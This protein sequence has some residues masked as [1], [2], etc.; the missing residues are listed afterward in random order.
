MKNK[1]K[2]KINLKYIPHKLSRKDK[3]KQYNELMKSK[4]MYKKDK[5]YIRK[6]IKGY[7]TKKSKHKNKFM[8]MYN[9]KSNELNL[10]LISKKTRCNKKG[11]KKIINKGMGAYFSSGSRPNQT[12]H[13]WGM[14]RLYSALTN[15]PSAVIDKNILINNCHK[16]SKT[17]AGL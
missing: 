14:A 11:L 16:Q 6:K 9:L 4:K 3:K 8:K 2:D 1:K 13:S 7:K 12:P 17:L 5:Y 10:S 15:G